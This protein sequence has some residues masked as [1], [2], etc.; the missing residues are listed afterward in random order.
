MRTVSLETSFQDGYISG[1]VNNIFNINE[2]WFY[3]NVYLGT[4]METGWHP[5]LSGCSH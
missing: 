4:K 5:G 3:K 1:T 2:K